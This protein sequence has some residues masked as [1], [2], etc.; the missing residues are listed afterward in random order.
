MPSDYVR[1]QMTE[2]DFQ[3]L[4]DLVWDSDAPVAYK[5]KAKWAEHRVKKELPSKSRRRVSA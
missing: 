5:I 3:A 2:E 1:I 4:V